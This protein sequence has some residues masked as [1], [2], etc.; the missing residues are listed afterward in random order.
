M[1]RVRVLLFNT[2]IVCTVPELCG[3]LFFI[4]VSVVY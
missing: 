1:A 4:Y 2:L 3:F